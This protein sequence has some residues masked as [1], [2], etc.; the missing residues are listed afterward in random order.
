MELN[1][2]DKIVKTV[3]ANILEKLEL[4]TQ[5]QVFDKSCLIL[6]PNIGIGMKDYLKYITTKYTDYQIFLG[7]TEPLKNT[8]ELT[9]HRQLQIIDFNL[10]DTSFNN[11]IDTVETIIIIGLK[12]SQLKALTNLDDTEE[13][14]HI[15]LSRAMANKSLNI[16]INSNA[17]II[18][19]MNPIIRD[20]EQLGIQV[21]NIQQR[22]IKT[23]ETIDLITENYV[24]DLYKNGSNRLVVNKKQ[25]ITPLA[26]DKLRE[27][28][29]TVE[30]IE[31]DKQ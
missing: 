1:N 25:L 21:V 27:C 18:K 4:K 14:N 8:T 11:I 22:H 20:I 12:L 13:I 24:M 9:K 30:Y 31:E 16:M 28:N 23:V 5:S 7:T 19:K 17:S 2:F 15:I 26:K 10:N 6:L 3:T 29:M